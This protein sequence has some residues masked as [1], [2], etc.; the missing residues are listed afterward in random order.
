MKE[1]NQ[2]LESQQQS[3]SSNAG[4]APLLDLIKKSDL[5]CVAIFTGAGVDPDG[6]ASGM[7]MRAIV[8]K[9]GGTADIYCRGT[10]NRPQNKTMREVL[11]LTPLSYSDYDNKESM[12]ST[13]ISVDGPRE[14]CPCDVDFII[15][16]HKPGKDAN[17]GTDVR[18]NGSAVSIMWE[19]AMEAGIDFNTDEGSIL[20]T[21]VVIGI[22]TDTNNFKDEVST[23]LDVEAYSYC[24]LRKDHQTFLSIENYP[25][26]AY[27]NDM[28]SLGWENK[29]LT[30]T[31]CIAGLGVI[32]EGRSGVISDLAEKYCETHGINTSLVAAMVE[33]EIVVS[34]RS[35]NTSL[36]VN[37]FMKTFGG[38]GKRGAGAA[39][40]KLP[41]G[42]F[43]GADEDDRKSVFDSYFSIITKKVISFAGDEA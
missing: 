2:V 43:G 20:A 4:K 27:Y 17:K 35:S 24:L 28:F 30:G 38:G 14:V 31:V 36:D 19:Y 1:E 34:M 26:P 3:L 15:D 16:H 5:S 10:F 18:T 21:A 12:Y 13:V 25:K 40:I 6:L 8:Q 22:E 32:A 23:P 9:F 7:L 42:I 11:G 41:V 39:R 37:E 29:V 33:G